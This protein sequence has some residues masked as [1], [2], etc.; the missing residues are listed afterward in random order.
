MQR[1]T[2]T[3]A[4]S[5]T[6]CRLAFIPVL[7]CWALAG[8]ARW[9]GLGVMAAFVSDIL[10]G[11]LARRMN[12]VTKL[13]GQLD[14]LADALLLASSVAWLVVFRPEMLEPPYAAWVAVALGSW[15]LL[16]AVGAVKFR[17]FLN[18]HLYTAKVSGVLGAVFVMDALAFDFHPVA[19]YLAF[20]SFVL[21]N[22]EGLTLM[23]TR[24]RV[25]EH[26]GSV[27]RRP[28]PQPEAEQ[29]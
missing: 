9:V 7:W 29:A 2:W 13:G 8:H 17:R 11:Q 3:L 16:I 15:T 10:D 18:L 20:G 28:R 19:F 1:S 27:L 5:V 23:L 4:S 25:D 21:S 12:R 6:A 22:A 14:S 26:M 24:S